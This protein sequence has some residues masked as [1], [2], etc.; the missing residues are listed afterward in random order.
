MEFENLKI[1]NIN[2]TIRYSPS[3][4][5]FISRNKPSHIIGLQ[6][7]GSAKHCFENQ[8]FTIKEGDLYF[9]NQE[10]DY[11]VTVLDKT[12][13]SFSIHFTTYEPILTSSFCIP[14]GSNSEYLKSLERIEQLSNSKTDEHRL[15]AEFYLFCSKVMKCRQKLYSPKDKRMEQ[16]LKYL[17]EHFKEKSCLEQAA[18][19]CGLSRRRFNDL[20]QKEYEITPNRYLILLKIDLA[21]KLLQTEYLQISEIASL[22]GFSD[23]YYFSKVF[24]QETGISPGEYKRAAT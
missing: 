24:K 19:L 22:C 8:T 10:E 2:F 12:T 14:C 20:F 16:T 23:V 3:K 13:E 17:H 9:L 18:L 21:K 7:S 5:E 4:R 11:D 15:T 1:K 6:L